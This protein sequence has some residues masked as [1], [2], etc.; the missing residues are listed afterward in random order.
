MPGGP[1]SGRFGLEPL[2][3]ERSITATVKACMAESRETVQP[4]IEGH[5]APSGGPADANPKP[6]PPPGPR[7]PSTWD[8]YEVWRTRVKNPEGAAQ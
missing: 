8:P 7:E 1:R 5:G 3:A 6:S 2:E 4:P